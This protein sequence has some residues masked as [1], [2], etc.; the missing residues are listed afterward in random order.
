MTKGEIVQAALK[1][2]EIEYTNW[3]TCLEHCSSIRGD[4]MK[5]SY[6]VKII[7]EQLNDEV[8]SSNEN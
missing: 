4:R 7:K 5:L 3:N 1:L 8:E 2:M 6:Y